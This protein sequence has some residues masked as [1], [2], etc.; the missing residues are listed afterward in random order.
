MRGRKPVPTNLKL[1]RGNPGKRALNTAE[2]RP[3]DIGD[4]PNDLCAVARRKWR[5]MIDK[6]A[7]GQV[8]TCADQDLLAEYC[9]LYVRKLEAE[10]QIKE[11]GA[12]VAAPNGFPTPSPWVAIA[13][14]CAADML[15]IA[16]ECGGTPSSRSRLQISKPGPTENPFA[17]H[18]KPPSR[19]P[20]LYD[21]DGQIDEI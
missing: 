10:K 7:W 12:V 13:N 16:A 3:G 15:K 17:R 9:R 19:F 5:R 14:R 20:E 18:G 1:I 6:A 11:H 8:L 2:P 21:G 4:P